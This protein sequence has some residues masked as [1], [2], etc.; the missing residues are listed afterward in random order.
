VTHGDAHGVKA[1]A[2]IRHWK[3]DPVLL[4]PNPIATC[5]AVVVAGGGVPMVVW[6]RLKSASAT[7]TSK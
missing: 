6:G 2:S 1:P 7:K 3:S 4:A 5:L